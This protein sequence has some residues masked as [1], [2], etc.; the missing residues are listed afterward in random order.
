MTRKC[1]Q[2]ALSLYRS[3]VRGEC[4]VTNP[5]TAELA[6]LTENAYRDVNIAFA[7]ELSFICD[8]LK[9]N[10]WELIGLANLPSAG[11][12]PVPAGRRRALHRGRPLVHRRDQP[13]RSEADPRGRLIDDAK[14]AY[15]V[16]RCASAPPR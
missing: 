5:R 15:V 1:A 11:E 9:V 2:R 8:K 12:H 4:R 16:A 3:V 10:V 7:N 13:E 14:P 6:K